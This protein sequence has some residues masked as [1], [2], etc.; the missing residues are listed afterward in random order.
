LSDDLGDYESAGEYDYSSDSDLEVD[1]GEIIP[2]NAALDVPRS[3]PSQPAH[4]MGGWRS[5]HECHTGPINKG[6]VVRIP[7][8]AFVT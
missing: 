6:K 4:P 7:D 1:E 3:G 5:R 8:M 2:P